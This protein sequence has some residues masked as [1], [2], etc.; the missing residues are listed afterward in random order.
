[1]GVRFDW[2]PVP[3]R[4]QKEAIEMGVLDLLQHSDLRP[5]HEGEVSVLLA[6]MPKTRPISRFHSAK[7]GAFLIPLRNS[8]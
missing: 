3:P 7:R 5:G 4:E 6:G 2:N 1:M 8:R